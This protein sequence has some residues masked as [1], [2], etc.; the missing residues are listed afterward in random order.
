M[1][2][3]CIGLYMV[4]PASQTALRLHSEKN[5]PYEI[6]VSVDNA[7]I[8]MDVLSQIEG[9]EAVSPILQLDFQ[10]VYGEKTASFAVDA[11]YSSYLDLQ[12]IDGVIF[13]DNTNMPY[14]L[15][16]EAA[17]KAFSVTVS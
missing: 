7:R 10:A 9:V 3:L 13:T 12:L 16:N 5:T 6:I 1:F 11:V 17:A 2:L 8:N 15:M 14:L 4:F